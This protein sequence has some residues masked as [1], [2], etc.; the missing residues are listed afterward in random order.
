[1]NNEIQEIRYLVGEA[2]RGAYSPTTPYGNANVVQDP[3]GLSIYRSLKPGN[4]GH[5]LTDTAWWFLIID[6]SSIKEESD[7]IRALNDAIAADETQR[8][9]NENGRVTVEQGRVDAEND[10]VTAE[11]IREARKLRQAGTS[12]R[13]I[14]ER[15]GIPNGLARYYLSKFIS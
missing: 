1:M 12:Y 7:R 6:L 5:P 13:E 8:V 4:V 10:R 9:E 14:E 3:T 11:Q 15:T 2:W